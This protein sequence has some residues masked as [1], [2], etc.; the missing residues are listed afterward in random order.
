MAIAPHETAAL[1][2][3]LAADILQQLGRR[4]VRNRARAESFF[5]LRHH[6]MPGAHSALRKV[7]DTA[8]AWLAFAIIL[9]LCS[10]LIPWLGI[11]A[12]EGSGQF[13][14]RAIA[15]GSW[16]FLSSAIVA[17]AQPHRAR[18][19]F[20]L[21]GIGASSLAVLNILVFQRGHLWLLAIAFVSAGVGVY[22]GRKFASLLA[23]HV[24]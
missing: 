1:L 13:L 10:A 19:W 20:W 2:N 12:G 5:K 21:F 11:A 3:I 18:R 23:R 8:L 4:P 17:I 16:I 14:A 22:V 15:F 6:V 24:R 7:R 9:A